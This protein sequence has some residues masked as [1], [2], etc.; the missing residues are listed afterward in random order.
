MAAGKDPEGTRR[1]DVEAQELPGRDRLQLLAL[2]LLGYGVVAGLLLL[3]LAPFVLVAAHLLLHGASMA[4]QHA[5]VLILPTV[6]AA[7]VLRTLWVRFEPPPGHA[8]APGEAPELQAEVERLRVAMGAPPLEGVVIDGDFNAKAAS[9][10]RA[11]GLLGHRHTLV[12]GL[13]LMRVLD[14]ERLA[15]VIAHEFGHFSAHDGGFAAWI[16]L[17][18]GTWYRLRDGLARHDLGFAWLLS[19]FYGWLAPRFDLASR[20]LTRAHEYAADGAAA[21]VVGAQPTADALATVELVSRRLDARFWPRLWARARSQGHPPVQLQAPMLQAAAGDLDP[22]RLAGPHAP[23]PAPDPGD[24][25]PTLAQR[26]QALGATPRACRGGEASA[27]LLGDLQ[28]RLERRLDDA[29][30]EAIRPQWQAV[31]EAAAPDRARLADLDGLS[32]P[33]AAQLAEHALL[34]EQVRI[35]LDPLPLYERALEADPDRVLALFRAGLLQ[36]RGGHDIDAGAARLRRAVELDPAAARP[37]LDEL[38]AIALDPDLDPV[39]A[40]AVDALCTQFAPLAGPDPAPGDAPP[41]DIL[42]AHDLDQAAL[43]RLGTRLACEPRVARA[44]IVRRRTALAE[45]PAHYLVLLDWRGSVAGE[46]SAL[47]QLVQSLALPGTRFE[48][49]TGAGRRRLAGQVRE[50]CGAPVYRKGAR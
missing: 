40:A 12:L 27:S 21:R 38:R 5:F 41:A 10:P 26:L 4:P 39:A 36:L 3:A 19:R 48:L 29:W 9:V 46:A 34:A 37:A 18:R 7:L 42:L 32:T 24:T 49:F 45:A 44:W 22:A 6:V 1:L 50:V 31:H 2:A 15:A 28:E 11:L 8:L 25:H 20:A 17:S 35:D 16:H 30:R 43:H 47:A 23:M 13:P 33:T 14:R